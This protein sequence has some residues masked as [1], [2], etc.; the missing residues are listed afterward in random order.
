MTRITCDDNDMR[1]TNSE[2]FHILHTLDSLP[3]PDQKQGRTRN[4]VHNLLVLDWKWDDEPIKTEQ[5][6]GEV[7]V[8]LTE[9]DQKI[10][11]QTLQ[12]AYSMDGIAIPGKASRKI[13]SVLDRLAEDD[14]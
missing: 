9:A 7:D 14:E 5:L 12:A 2:R 4:K 13:M 11:R 6:E 10:L 3:V 8:D 1:I